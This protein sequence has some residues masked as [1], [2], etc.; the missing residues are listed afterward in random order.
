MKSLI[1][2][3]SAL[4]F[5]FTVITLMTTVV[6][7]NARTAEAAPCNSNYWQPT[8]VHDL[9][10][11]DGPWFV[12]PQG[13][14]IKLRGNDENSWVNHACE[15]IRAYGIR[16][17]RGYTTCR[18]Y[19]RIQCGCSRNIP[20]NSTCANFLAGRGP[21]SNSNAIPGAVQEAVIHRSLNII[22]TATAL[23]IRG[24]E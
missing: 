10:R 3:K 21:A 24:R 7:F 17:R 9:E 19:T 8:F 11:P 23:T 2:K 18:Q 13:T 20:G 16:D 22:P 14:F 5:I 6:F 12:T 1:L 4:C 15:L